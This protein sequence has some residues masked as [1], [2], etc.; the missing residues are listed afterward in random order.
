[1]SKDLVHWE[2]TG[3]SLTFLSKGADA[4]SV[5]SGCVVIHEGVPTAVYTRAGVH[6]TQC[7]ARSYD[8]MKT[9]QREPNNPVLSGC[10]IPESPWWHDPF[11]WKENDGWYMI[12]GGGVPGPNGA[13]F[14][15]RSKNLV[16]WETLEPLCIG[17]QGMC[18]WSCPEL[19]PLGNKYLF[20]VSQCGDVRYSIGTYENHKFVAG[21]WHIMDLGLDAG[22][23]GQRSLEDD[24]GRRIMWG[25]IPGGGTEGYP[26]NGLIT[27]PRILTLR[28][29][30]RLGVE[31]APELA[32]LRGKHH[33]FDNLALTPDGDNV[34]EN[35]KGDCLEINVE[36]EPISAHSYG[37]DLRRSPDGKEKTTIE[38]DAV[39][40]RL[41]SGDKGG[42]FELLENEK[43]LR[44]HI[45]LDKSVV[46]IY[47]NGRETLTMRT[48]PKRSDSLGMSLFARG[49]DR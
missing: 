23:Y 37:L 13:A 48:L 30:G 26:W 49:G 3:V 19:L 8:N 20:V 38:Y 39:R 6:E 32:V 15:Y 45:Y 17:D 28:P 4:S 33:H 7:I 44:L 9:W 2:R 43:T 21:S 42:G 16:Q 24:K 14:L 35:V 11:V 40:K 31:P 12:L 29:D 36:F 1:M 18:G 46:E 10:E 34:L 22:F 25:W 41:T 5:Y 27:L 47:A